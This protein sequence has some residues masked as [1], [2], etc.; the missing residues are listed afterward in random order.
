MKI[1]LLESP[2]SPG[3]DNSEPST[4]RPH[5]AKTAH[6]NLFFPHVRQPF[7]CSVQGPLPHISTTNICTGLSSQLNSHSRHYSSESPLATTN[8]NSLQDSYP[9]PCPSDS[10]TSANLSRNS[11]DTNL[12]LLL[13]HHLESI[14]TTVLAIQSSEISGLPEILTPRAQ[15]ILR[16]VN[17]LVSTESS[18]SS[19]RSLR[20]RHYYESPHS[21]LW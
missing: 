6:P 9:R 12:K 13:E 3:P 18:V 21:Y 4:I 14:L 17:A 7:S 16:A 1:T 10:P 19:P 15:S 20:S 2:A 8:N 11:P 5:H